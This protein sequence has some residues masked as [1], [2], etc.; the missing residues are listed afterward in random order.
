M[1][2]IDLLGVDNHIGIKLVSATKNE[3]KLD[4]SVSLRLRILQFLVPFLD[5]LNGQLEAQA[6][7]TLKSGPIQVFGD[8]SLTDGSLQFKGFPTAIENIK[9]AIEFSQSKIFLNSITANLGQSEVVGAGTI[10][11]KGAKNVVVQ[12]RA[13]ADSLEITFP[14]KIT[15]AGRADLSLSGIWLPYTLKINYKV[16]RGLVEKDFGEDRSEVTLIK[17]S[18]FLP[19]KQIEQQSPSLLLDVAVDASSGVVIKNQ[20]LQGAATGILKIKGTPE[21]PIILGKIEIKP[22]SKIIFKDKPFE[23]QTANLQFLESNDNNPDIYISALARVSDYDVNLL[24]QGVP[25]KNMAIKPT[26]QPPLSEPDIFSL[27]ALGMTST[28]LDQNLSSEAQQQQTSIELLASITNQSTIN[29]KI[30]EKLGLTVQLAPSVDSTRNIAVPKVVVSKNILK[31]LNASYA[32]SLTGD[33]QNHEVKLHYLFNP[34][35]SGILNYQNKETND[36]DGTIQNLN[37]N[38]GVFG[39][40]FEYKKEFKW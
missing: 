39:G 10:E 25:N 22:G 33:N 35:W 17:A 15:T 30:Q 37:Q 1:D 27:L 11:V 34:N 9:T 21:N 38:E 24:V 36:T 6:K 20:L 28:K 8:G 2:P 18:R 29:K 31:K 5:S 7:V 3:T 40:D 14:D 26:S 12:L 19:P 23:I 16:N 13:Q 32:R 4:L